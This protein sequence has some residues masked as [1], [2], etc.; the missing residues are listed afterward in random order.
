MYYLNITYSLIK[1]SIQIYTVLN[2]SCPKIE[3]ISGAHT[4]N[5]GGFLRNT[6]KCR[7]YE[8]CN[9]ARE[10]KFIRKCIKSIFYTTY[11]TYSLLQ[12][13]SGTNINNKC[14]RGSAG[15]EW[16]IEL[17]Q[18]KSNTISFIFKASHSCFLFLREPLRCSFKTRRGKGKTGFDRL[19]DPWCQ[20][21]VNTNSDWKKNGSENV[22]NRS[23]QG[24]GP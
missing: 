2:N 7:K 9:H 4:H 13:C 3:N 23:F 6:L 16:K 14:W 17:S 24:Y 10:Q 19:N 15:T 20:V 18:F 1:W 8:K 22:P 11:C 5:R 12:T 21:A